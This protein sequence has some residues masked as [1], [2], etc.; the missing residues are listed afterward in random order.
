MCFCR[1][2]RIHSLAPPVISAAQNPVPPTLSKVLVNKGFVNESFV[3]KSKAL[4]YSYSFFQPSEGV[5]PL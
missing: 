2:L 3:N 4:F 5:L 1:H